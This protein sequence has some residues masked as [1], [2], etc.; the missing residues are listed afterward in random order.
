MKKELKKS[1]KKIEKPITNKEL[2]SKHTK[3]ITDI[4]KRELYYQIC[5]VAQLII[6]IL[7]FAIIIKK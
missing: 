7:M 3:I 5:F 6:N 4:L 1:N 2:L